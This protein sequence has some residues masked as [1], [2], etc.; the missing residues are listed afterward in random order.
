MTVDFDKLRDVF[1]DAVERHLP[2][3]WDAYLDQACA[4]DEE[5]RRQAALLLKAHAESAGPLEQR[6]VGRDW[7]APYA[8]PTERPGTIIGPYKLLEQI[9]EGGF[10]VVFMASQQEPIHRKVA[11]KVL[12]PG[13]DS[14][15]VIGRFEVERQALALMDHPNIAKVLDAGQTASGRPYFVMDLV[16]GLP[17]TDYCDQAQLVPRERLELFV[18]LCQAV[19]HAHQKGIIH[20]DL[21]PSNVLV[22]VHDTMPVVK[23]IDFGVAKALGQQLTEKTLFT[24]F[25]QMIGTPLYMSP[26][27]AGQSG[28]DVDTRS[29][30]YSLGVLLYELLT[31]TTPFG[32]EQLKEVGYDEIR[33]IIREEEP[34]SPSTRIGTLGQ[35]ATTVSTHRKSDPKRLSQLLRGE[36]DW[37]VM[38]ALEKDRNRR[39]ETANGMAMDVERYLRNEPVL[40]GPPSPRYRLRKFVSRNRG[41]VL[42]AIAMVIL[43]V[44]GIVG[45]TAGLVRALKESA[46][47]ELGRAAEARRRQQA[48]D[49]LDAMSSRVVKDWLAQQRNR[50]L[51]ERQREFLQQALTAYEDF[52]RDVGDD[53][54]SRAGVADAHRRVGGIQYM[55]GQLT[56][57]E[58]AY[59][60]SA[61]LYARLTADFPGTAVYQQ[62]RGTVYRG[63]GLLLTVR[64]RMAEAE[65]VYRDAL[66]TQKQ[67]AADFPNE[68]EYRHD[69]GMTAHD[70]GLLLV[71]TA[72]YTDAEKAYG[73]ALAIQ[74]Q[75]AAD[76]PGTT[77]GVTPFQ[78]TLAGTFNDLGRLWQLVGQ[79]KKAEDAY[80]TALAIHQQLVDRF[81]SWV[82]YRCDL[83]RHHH[84]LG[85]LLASVG[86]TAEA[87]AAY[88]DA[89]VIRKQLTAESPAVPGYLAELAESHFSCGILFAQSGRPSE[90]EAAYRDALA[91]R[92]QLAADFRAN[93]NFR[94]NHA[95]SYLGLGVLFQSTGRPLEAEAAYREALAIQKHL[96]ADFPK[97]PFYRRDLANSYNNL[98]VLY[99]FTRRPKKAE[100][101]YRDAL[102]LGK[103]LVTDSPSVPD[104]ESLLAATLVN[105]GNL[106]LIR[107]DYAAARRMFEEAL[108]HHQAA[109]K[110]NPRHSDYRQFLRNNRLG[111]TKTFLGLG[112]HGAAAATAAQMLEAAVDPVMDRYN[113]ACYLAR[114][115]PLAQQDKRL[116]HEKRNELVTAYADRAMAMLRQAVQ[117][118][119]RDV[120]HIGKDADLDSLRGRDDFKNLVSELETTVKKDKGG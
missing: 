66:A 114:C 53:E 50:N 3:Q 46:A 58:R 90:A 36:L 88:H 29:D 98:G 117:H 54:A 33:R 77:P 110:A 76:F 81:P 97:A 120:S 38:K 25:A 15:Q 61:E 40:A 113:T 112:D 92:K 1:H 11:L 85:N 109:L 119:Y 10:G 70:L 104:Y 80:R 60:R 42:A 65:A 94:H 30:I 78:H 20:R 82:P 45:T 106:Y 49:A 34:P 67:L 37:I 86:R 2:E 32:K 56:E 55:L 116:S 27:Q 108:P 102:M 115:V 74:K 21:K 69:L 9:G 39:Y 17:I 93:A 19:Q 18:H 118:G 51:S 95:Q 7:T 52:A 103:Q 68:P 16:K 35:A 84:N 44:A 83:A 14:K 28:L 41:P 71:D 72:R 26:E 4:G 105:L 64:G 89:L 87:E 79:L 57:A 101:A 91:I 6:A 63:L 12:K 5:L 96:V 48:R 23:V 107:Q 47:R 73:D 8:A 22:T 43:L 99:Q 31:G 100:D 59:R 13:M 24:G 111:L 75:L 62:H